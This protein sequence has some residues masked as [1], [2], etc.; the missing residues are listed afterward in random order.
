MVSGQRQDLRADAFN[1]KVNSVLFLR[2]NLTK[3]GL[4]GILNPASKLALAIAS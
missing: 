2:C 4:S 1:K 3:C